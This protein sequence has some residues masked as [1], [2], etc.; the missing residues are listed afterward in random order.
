MNAL[1]DRVAIVTEAHP[2]RQPRWLLAT[3]LMG[4]FIVNVDVAVVNVATPSIHEQLNASGSE[5]QLV[6]SGYV[7]S[8][9][10]LLITGARLGG[11]YGYRRLFLIGLCV[12]TLASLAC[13]L[14]PSALVLIVARVVQGIGAALLVP[15]VLVGIQLNFSGPARVRALGFYAVALSVGAVAGQMLG[16]VLISA[17]L[18]GTAWRPIFLINLPIG[19]AV[20][21]AALAFLPKDAG[22]RT[23]RLDVRGVGTLSAAMLLAVLPLILGHTQGWPLW[24]WLSLGASL[25]AFAAFIGIERHLSSKPGKTPLVNLRLFTEPAI[26][27]GFIGYAAASLTYFA[28][29]F[30]LALYLQQGLGET[31]LYSG[32]AL[33][34]WV[35]AFGIGGP[36]YPRLP[37]RILPL[38]A[39]I[40]YLILA[41]A[42]L[43]LSV[44]LFSGP[45]GGALLVALLGMGGLGLGLGFTANLRRLTGAVQARYA[46]DMSG[47]ITTIA[48]T[49]GVLGV[50]TFGTAWFSLVPAPDRDSATHGFAIVCAGFTA[51]AVVAAVAA[52]FS[53]RAAATE[54]ADA[55]PSPR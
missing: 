49:A 55:L 34:S 30:T 10:M 47:L 3:L 19:A 48:Q 23:Q 50:A 35:T 15:Q 11:M 45:L 20:A 24:T 18:F 31:A 43:A 26:A 21:A 51:M 7:L 12:F 28:L 41:A 9:A 29:L 32:L 40:G 16:G 33:V 36:V 27:W 53:I 44:A 25:V 1:I 54:P 38:V 37:E 39:P 13:G 4:L 46:S 42:Y 2:H 5:L 52:Y 8:Y 6:V 14:A 17:N 22:G